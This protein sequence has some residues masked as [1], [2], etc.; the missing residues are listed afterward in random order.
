MRPGMKAERRESGV[1]AIRWTCEK[2]VADLADYLREFGDTEEAYV[3][4]H[5]ENSPYERREIDGNLLLNVG[6][7]LM[8]DLLIGAGGTV[9]SN[10]N[11]RIGVGDS[12]TA[13]AATQTDLQA[14]S[15][16]LR[17]AM[18]ATFPSRV[19]QTMSWKSSFTTAEANFAWQEW[20]IANAAASPSVLNRK[21]ESL[22]TKTTGTW[23]LQGD[24]SIV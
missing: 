20:I 1:W 23:T 24:V 9:F 3:R 12:S 7:A 11:A 8:L 15:N 16:K 21:V 5:R 6:I 13:A 18:D 17:K 2:F 19:A 10:A 4:F 22:G 14:A